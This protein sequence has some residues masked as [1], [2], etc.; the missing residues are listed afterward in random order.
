LYR[1]RTNDTLLVAT[2]C[3][4]ALRENEFFIHH[5]KSHSLKCGTPLDGEAILAGLV[6]QRVG[7]L[8]YGCHFIEGRI[9]S[10]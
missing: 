8:K 9:S 1:R 2:V 10:R 6:E 4:V 5:G 7:A 3:Y